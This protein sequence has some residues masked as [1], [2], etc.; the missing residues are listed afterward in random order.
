M[1]D[2][3]SDN[4]QAQQQPVFRMQKMYVKDLSFENP[5]APEVFLEQ[6]EPKVDV[7]LGLKHKKLDREDHY[8]VVLAVTATVTNSKTEKTLFLIEVEH[9]GVFLLKNI[10][11]EHLPAVLSVECAALLFPFTRQIISQAS[12]DG[13][14]IPFLMEPVNFLALY[15]NSKQ[16]KS[17]A[18]EQTQ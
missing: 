14:F 10:P 16:Q 18:A 11:V 13:G 4:V 5:N 1:T 15:E 9:A 17:Q 7:N 12:V 8:E 6:G 2:Q 3:N